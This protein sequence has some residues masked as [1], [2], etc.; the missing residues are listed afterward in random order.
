MTKEEATRH[1]KQIFKAGQ[2]LDEVYDRETIDRIEAKLV[3]AA[4]Y[5]EYR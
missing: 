1:E 4:K 2:A 3:V 5:E